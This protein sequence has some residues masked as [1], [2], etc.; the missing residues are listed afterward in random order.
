MKYD[1]ASDIHTDLWTGR[2]KHMN[3]ASLKSPD[4]NVLV[5]AGD[6]SNYLEEVEVVLNDTSAIY[7]HVVFTDGNHEGYFF[8]ETVDE[9]ESYL[10]TLA[11]K[12]PNVTYLNGT[13]IFRYENTVFIG[14]NGWYDFRVSEPKYSFDQAKQAWARGSNDPARINFGALAPEVRAERHATLLADQVAKLQN[15][16]VELVVTTHTIPNRRLAEW[17]KYTNTPGAVLDGAYYNTEMDRVRAAD[18]G[19]LIKVWNYGHTHQR[20][21]RWIDGI[22]YVNNSRGYEVESREHGRWFLA[23]I[24]TEDQ[25]YG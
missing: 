24:N 11:N 18:V 14:A 22:R 16:G 13:N 15:C 2:A 1:V 9:L 7:N 17:S 5:L 12:F 20:F 3:W 4:S 23:Q 25:S 19:G 21:D 10:A 6:T 8:R